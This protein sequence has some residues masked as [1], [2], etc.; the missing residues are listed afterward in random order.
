MKVRTLVTSTW[1][2]YFRRL[3]QV[4]KPSF[5]LSFTK[6]ILKPRLSPSKA[7]LCL[8]NGVNLKSVFPKEK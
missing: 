6:F 3:T 7:L 5:E 2:E 1:K 8:D 4:Q